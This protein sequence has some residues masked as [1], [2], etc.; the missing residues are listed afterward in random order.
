MSTDFAKYVHT[1]FCVLANVIRIGSGKHINEKHVL[2]RNEGG[3]VIQAV[4]FEID[5]DIT[6]INVGNLRPNFWAFTFIIITF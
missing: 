1:S 3:P 4:Y 6:N 5:F 2:L